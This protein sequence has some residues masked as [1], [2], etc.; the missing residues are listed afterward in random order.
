MHSKATFHVLQKPTAGSSVPEE[1]LRQQTC[2]QHTSGAL[3]VCL[4]MPHSCPRLEPPRCGQCRGYPSSRRKVS[5]VGGGR[6]QGLPKAR[7]N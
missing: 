7:P 4:L 1:Q 6:D 5:A 2:W 3:G